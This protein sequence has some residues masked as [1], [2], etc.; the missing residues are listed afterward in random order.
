[1]EEFKKQCT[2]CKEWYPATTE[3]F[4]KKSSGKFG[5]AA[6]CKKCRLVAEGKRY[7]DNAEQKRQAAKQHYLLHRDAKLAYAKTYWLAKGRS[8]KQK[9]RRS[10]TTAYYRAHPDRARE[11]RWR[12]YG[13]KFGI[14]GTIRFAEWEAL[15]EQY[16]HQCLCCLRKEPEITL[17]PDHVIPLVHGGA[18]DITNIQPLC[19]VCNTKKRRNST[20]YRPQK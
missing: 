8:R 13:R 12:E 3:Y 17:V 19:P 9:P 1:M 10:Y 5:L 2:V 16:Q 15:K 11:K 14:E 18:N 7:R 6:Q 20:D 4:H